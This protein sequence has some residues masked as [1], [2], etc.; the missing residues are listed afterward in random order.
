MGGAV[1]EEL[2]EGLLVPGNAVRLNQRE[3]VPRSEAGEGGLGKVRVGGEEVF[4]GGVAISE[5]A[6]AAA[7][8]EDLLAGALGAL[9]HEDAAPAAPCLD[10]AHEAGGAGAEDEDVDFGHPR[11]GVDI[12][13]GKIFDGRTILRLSFLANWYLKVMVTMRAPVGVKLTSVLMV[14]V[15]L[16]HLVAILASP[17]PLRW[18]MSHGM[19]RFIS[20]VLGAAVVG[21]AVSVTE[22]LVLW[23]Y[24]RGRRWAMWLVLLGC[25]LTFVSLRH[26]IIGPP[27]SHARVLIIYYRIAVA[28]V[29]MM[30][31]C[32]AQARSWFT[33]HPGHGMIADLE[34]EQ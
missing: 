21:I 7:G 19:L 1:A 18:S 13:I 2:T 15:V 25:L 28:V 29:V 27:V 14:V 32:T 11:R 22:C 31:L 8:D 17:L 20:T 24:W 33:L 9:E 23:F 3:E 26:F 6:A 34:G 5:V 30:Y 12:E 10:G 16:L 4:R